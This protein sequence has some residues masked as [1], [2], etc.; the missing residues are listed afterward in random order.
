MDQPGCVSREDM[1]GCLG[2]LERV[3]R[4]LGGGSLT[5]RYAMPIIRA[6]YRET[7][8]PI[9]ICDIGTA[10]ADIPR[11]IISRARREHIPIQIT[12]VEL[13][14][15]LAAEAEKL[16]REFPE[17][18]IKCADAREVLRAAGE[19][20]FDLVT[21]CLFTHH[22]DPGEVESWLMLMD[23][24]ATCGWIINDLERHPAAY[25]GIRLFGKLFSSNPVFLHDGSLS[26]RRAYSP[27]EWRAMI[28][29]AG[30]QNITINRHWAWRLIIAKD[31]FRS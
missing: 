16:C 10:S 11:V 6:R 19:H 1:V 4:W 28:G 31:R 17:I 14:A 29:T 24:A 21:A 25:C 12:A 3:N 30:L 20:P 5:C 2:G 22:F 27:A 26:V 7:G 18:T 9:R 8:K 15:D 13:N 23:A